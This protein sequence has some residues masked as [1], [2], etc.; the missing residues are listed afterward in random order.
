MKDILDLL[1]H[2]HFGTI[3]EEACRSTVVND[4][5]REDAGKHGYALPRVNISEEQC[6]AAEDLGIFLATINSREV[7][8]K[9]WCQ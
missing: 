6:S 4:V 3:T 9:Q 5:I 7:G 2:F 1:T 8:L